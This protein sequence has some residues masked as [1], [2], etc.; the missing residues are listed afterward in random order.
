MSEMT[1]AAYDALIRELAR[2]PR[3]L[4]CADLAVIVR[5]WPELPGEALADYAADVATSLDAPHPI[6]ALGQCVELCLRNRARAY[7][8]ADVDEMREQIAV[9]EYE[10]DLYMHREAV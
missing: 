9:E 2:D 3:D 7:I 1:S 4:T 10:D 6:V 5:E 8:R